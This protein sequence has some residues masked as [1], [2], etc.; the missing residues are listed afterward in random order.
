MQ[1]G[2]LTAKTSR[3]TLTYSLPRSLQNYKGMSRN[4]EHGVGWKD[5]CNLDTGDLSLAAS[6]G[7]L[8]LDYDMD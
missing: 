7:Y 8:T 2:G 1:R 4:S 5:D 6:S 3:E